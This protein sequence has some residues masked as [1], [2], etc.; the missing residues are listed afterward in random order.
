[1]VSSLN[2]SPIRRE[3]GEV[4]DKRA[5]QTHC[6][7]D[8]LKILGDF[9]TL[10]IIDVLSQG[11][12]RFCQLQRDLN[13]INPVTLT[14]RLKMLEKENIIER[15]EETVDKL[16]VVYALTDKGKGILPILRQMQ[17]FANKFL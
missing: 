15:R 17:V 2:P 6:S 9:R 12:K 13:G 4:R 10:S 11:E 8:G 5:H 16:S 1:M 7:S 14:N 3:Q